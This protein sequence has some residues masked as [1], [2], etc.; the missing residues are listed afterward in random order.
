MVA[1]ATAVGVETHSFSASAVDFP[2]TSAASRPS[3]AFVALSAICLFRARGPFLHPA[4]AEQA[5]RGLEVN[6]PHA[7]APRAMG[8]SKAMSSAMERSATSN[9]DAGKLQDGACIQTAGEFAGR[10]AAR[11]ARA[12]ESFA[13]VSGRESAAEARRAITSSAAKTQLHMDST[14][15]A[16]GGGPRSR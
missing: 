9:F 4:L 7:A 3:V 2:K 6:E 1:V 10:A 13:D 16:W 14:K 5:G 8:I 15:S 11:L 12:S